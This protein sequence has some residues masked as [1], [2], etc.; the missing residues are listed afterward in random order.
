MPTSF[1]AATHEH[2]TSLVD[3]MFRRV[4]VGWTNTMGFK[5][6]DKAAEAV[7]GVYGWDTARTA[8]EAADY[9]AYLTRMHAVR[10]H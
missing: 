7:A 10:A 5:A 1:F 8:K 4:G 6:A 2:A 9:R 3:L